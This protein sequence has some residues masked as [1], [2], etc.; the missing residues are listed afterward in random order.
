[1]TCIVALKHESDVYVGADS[2][3]VN[4]HYLTKHIRKDRKVFRNGPFIIGFTTSFRMGQLLEHDLEVP[5]HPGGM[6]DMTYMVKCVVPAIRNCF[7]QGGILR[8]DS[9]VENGGQFIFVYNK[10]IYVIDSDFQ[11]AWND[12]D[13]ASVGGASDFAM[14][15]LYTSSGDPITRVKKALSTAEHFNAGVSAPFNIISTADL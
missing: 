6:S 13:Y 2:I 11:I 8:T 15:S 10:E 7:R 5:K 1:M 3:A 14:G 12:C 4:T 9:N